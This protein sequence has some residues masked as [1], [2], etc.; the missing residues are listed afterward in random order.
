MK[1]QYTTPEVV[2]AEILMNHATMAVTS[3]VQEE[4]LDGTENG[5]E[6]GAGEDYGWDED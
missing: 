1:K 4:A 5:F 2:V 6:F 3:Q